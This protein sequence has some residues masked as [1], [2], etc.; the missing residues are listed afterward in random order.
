VT[1][2]LRGAAAVA[3]AKLAYRLFRL[4]FDGPRWEQLAARGARLQRP[5]WASTSTKDP[6][7]PDTMYVDNLVGPATIN[8][9]PEATIAAFE[10]HGRVVR[11]IDAD[12]DGA[13]AVM[14]RLSEVG[15]DMED[16]GLTLEEQGAAGFRD[17]LAH[18]LR[19]LETRA[20]QRVRR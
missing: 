2:A 7:R 20:L 12:L 14:T 17:S 13:L 10:D 8:T 3:Q 1:S 11:S 6:S 19:T 5:L 15:I 18:V 16:V 4:R 9:M